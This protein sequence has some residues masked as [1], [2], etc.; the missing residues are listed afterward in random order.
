MVFARL[1]IHYSN[2][3]IMNYTDLQSINQDN[4][5]YVFDDKLSLQMNPKWI[6]EFWSFEAKAYFMEDP[7]GIRWREMYD[8]HNVFESFPA[9]EL[10]WEQIRNTFYISGYNKQYPNYFEIDSHLKDRLMTPCVGRN[11]FN[12]E[13]NSEYEY[14]C[15]L[16]IY[17]DIVRLSA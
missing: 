1:A 10:S 15:E 14:I 6:S 17:D 12:L 13:S 9:P 11:G 5:E 3:R 16:E 8:P 4:I 7:R 2:A